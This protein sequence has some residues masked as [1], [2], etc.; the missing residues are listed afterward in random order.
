M[1][2]LEQFLQAVGYHAITVQPLLPMYFH[3][4]ISA[5]FPIYTGAH[6]S[7]SRPKS[8]AKSAKRKKQDNDDDDDDNQPDE[9][10]KMEGMSPS[11]AIMLP[12][13]A[14][15]TLTS[16][17][18]II[19][20]LKDPAILNKI[21]NW[22][23]S[24]F[25]VLALARLINDCMGTITSF[26]FPTMFKSNGK[27]WEI[28]A[29]ARL[30]KVRE[31]STETRDSPLP[32]LLS[33]LPLPTSLKTFTWNIR[34]LPSHRLHIRARMRY[35]FA[36]HVKIGPQ[37]ILG[38]LIALA[39]QIHFNLIDK[40][41]WLTNALG[42]SLAYSALQIMSPTTS[43][44]GTMVLCALF[45]Y[46]IYFVFFT[47]V[48]VAVATQLDI[49]AKLLFPR[50]RVPGQDPDKQALSMLGLG[51]IVLP[52]MMIGFA[53]RFDLFLFYVRKQYQR[54]IEVE[55]DAGKKKLEQ[56][57]EIDKYYPAKGGW[58]ERIWASKQALVT[59][60]R[61]HGTV[62][63]KT[64]F[65]AS[66]VGY[67]AGL[68]CTL[69]V[70]QIFGHAQPALLYL[71]PSVLGSLWGTA[72]IKGDLGRLWK[73]TEA[74]DEDEGKKDGKKEKIGQDAS[75]TG[76][77]SIFS[78]S[79]IEKKP[80]ETAKARVDAGTQTP[81]QDKAPSKHKSAHNSSTELIFLSITLPSLSSPS[82]AAEPP[83]KASTSQ[84]SNNEKPEPSSQQESSS[85][86]GTNQNSNAQGKGG[87]GEFELPMGSTRA[88]LKR[89]REEHARRSR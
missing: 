15:I 72:L 56:V 18:F 27:I 29:K 32:G 22:Y 61:Y 57:T 36:A 39:A 7:L 77:K 52:G 21:L 58:G 47:P 38:F 81:T 54:D 43:W 69:G 51:D 65:H 87:G 73:Y 3:L 2:Q 6:A 4:I 19:Q 45:I 1:D 12:L 79:K 17:Y 26:A 88:K 85:K 84:K 63:P 74:E 11:D 76:W 59:S 50:P 86:A 78:L 9:E 67:V 20:W 75:A 24:V 55:D 70:M 48:M 66:L 68:M 5:L 33:R 60:E 62:F 82:L 64:Y 53:L 35:V 71:V 46:D 25:G 89:M 44:T 16:L 10:Q 23:F 28:D 83:S 41:W 30:A 34:A 42:F 31:S 40:P 14:G 13:L 8:A 49:P 37:G 80:E